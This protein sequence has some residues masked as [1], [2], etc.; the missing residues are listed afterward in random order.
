MRRKWLT[1]KKSILWVGHRQ[2]T[3][4]E[5][6]MLKKCGTLTELVSDSVY[7]NNQDRNSKLTDVLIEKVGKT[8]TNTNSDCV[9]THLN[10]A[11]AERLVEVEGVES[12]MVIDDGG[13]IVSTLKKTPVG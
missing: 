5:K 2:P 13:D 4:A 3:T 6:K 8:T 7:R 9:V 11:V 10:S 12:V 1:N